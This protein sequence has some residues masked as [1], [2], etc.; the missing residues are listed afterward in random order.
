MIQSHFKHLKHYCAGLLL[1]ALSGIAQAGPISFFTASMDGS[2]E[3]PP[4]GSTASGYAQFWIDADN[5]T[6]DWLLD[7]N[8]IALDQITGLHIHTGLPGVAGPVVINF[9]G[10]LSGS[11]LFDL[12]TLNV[13]LN[14][15]AYYVNL[16]TLTFP[17]GEIRGQLSMPTPSSLLLLVAGGLLLLIAWRRKF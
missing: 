15:G 1:L 3:T 14:P 13:L 7:I 6:I 9:S 2:Q 16:H 5:M 11:D 10:Q 8:G 12:D 4:N 17:G